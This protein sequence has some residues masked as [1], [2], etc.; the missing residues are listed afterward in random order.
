MTTNTTTI[1]SNSVS[2]NL[3]MLPQPLQ[4]PHR[5]QRNHI[6]AAQQRPGVEVTAL[7]QTSP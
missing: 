6:L 1:S 4:F 2:N 5:L 7:V 3:Q